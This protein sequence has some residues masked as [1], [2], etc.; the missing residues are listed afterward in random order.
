[1]K[2]LQ[3][4]ELFLTGYTWKCYVANC[5]KR[6][7]PTVALFTQNL[8]GSELKVEMDVQGIRFVTVI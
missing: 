2:V 8:Q 6:V 3:S 4:G 7:E 5:V 1:M